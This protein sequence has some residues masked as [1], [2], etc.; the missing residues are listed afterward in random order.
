MLPRAF[1]MVGMCCGWSA[2]HGRLPCGCLDLGVGE[3]GG[4]RG[5][6]CASSSPA[7]DV[8][9]DLPVGSQPVELGQQRLCA[10]TLGMVGGGCMLRP[11]GAG[12]AQR[13]DLPETMTGAGWLDRGSPTPAWLIP[14]ADAGEVPTVTASVSSAYLGRAMNRA[15]SKGG[16]GGRSCPGGRVASPRQTGHSIQPAPSG[17]QSWSEE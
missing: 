10:V 16:C 1:V 12:G 4:D 7:Q 13:S 2:T 15:G 17:R 3:V 8:V 14:D 9:E 5:D 6:G 11:A